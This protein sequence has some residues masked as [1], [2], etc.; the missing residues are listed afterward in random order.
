MIVVGLGAA[1]CSIAKAFS[2]FPQY[3]A[4]TID[5][6]KDS[7]ITI[8]KQMSHED[9]DAHFPDLK[10]RLKFKNEEVLFITCGSGQISGG[11]LR[12]LQQLHQNNEVR[13]L[14]IQ[15]DLSLLSEVQR[16]Q[17]KVVRNVLQ[18]YARSGAISRV[19]LIDNVAIERSVGDVSISGYYDVLNQAIINTVHMINVFENSDPVIGNFITPTEISRIA[20][21]G[22]V[23]LSADEEK[24]NWFYELTNARDVVYYYGINK[25]DLKNDGTLFRK[26]NQFVKSKFEDQMSVSYG[27]FETTYEQKYCYC[28]MYT[29]VVQSYAELLDDQDIS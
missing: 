17:E 2:K 23:D 25:D 14:Y 27:V 11:A 28:I 12:L 18:E 5:T 3:E 4:Y 22:I 6:H 1:G 29:S 9:Y 13:A 20:T 24:E 19:Y 15:P 8:K 26:I 21:V 7:D 16:M 10:A